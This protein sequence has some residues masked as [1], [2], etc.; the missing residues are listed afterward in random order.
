MPIRDNAGDED[1]DQDDPRNRQEQT[2][3]EDVELPESEQRQ[4]EPEVEVIEAEADDGENE[5]DERI[6]QPDDTGEQPQRRRETAAERRQ[7]AKQAK[8]R[9]KRE[10]NFQQREL[11]RLQKTVWELTQGQVV[12]RV[13]ELDNRISTANAEIAQWERVKA[14]AITKHEGA[15]AVAADNFLKEAQQKRD[16]AL[17]DKQQIAQQAQQQRQQPA[18]REPPFEGYKRDFFAANPWYH[19]DGLDEDSLI[20]KAIDHAVAQEYRPTD[21]RYWE[22]LQKRVDARLGKN[23]RQQTRDDSDEDDDVEDEPVR[24]TRRRAPPVGGSSRSNSTGGGG[25]TQQIRLSPARVQ[26]MKDAGLWDDPAV[27]QRMAKKYSEYDRQ[28]R[29]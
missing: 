9:D 19:Q 15:D 16:Q 20:V 26:A 22:E 17:W 8:E 23:R 24:N 7:R 5:E 10:L 13:T 4:E 21:P 1:R 2:E 14:A 29:G 25:G 28:N 11:E 3:S 18:T 6:A 27:R 12:T